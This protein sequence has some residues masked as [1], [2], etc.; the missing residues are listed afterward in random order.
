MNEWK[1]LSRGALLAGLTALLEGVARPL[2][3]SPVRAAVLAAVEA[4][5]GW[6][7]AP[8]RPETE[9]PTVAQ[10]QGM[11][12][13][14]LYR[15]HVPGLLSLTSTVARSSREYAAIGATYQILCFVVLQID[16]AEGAWCPGKPN[17]LPSDVV[18]ANGSPS[19]R[20]S[21][22]VGRPRWTQRPSGRVSRN[23]SRRSPPTFPTPGS[24]L[25]RSRG[26]WTWPDELRSDPMAGTLRGRDH[27]GAEGRAS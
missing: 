9:A 8:E 7:D 18:E 12:S 20:A 2:P 26:V 24:P 17:V 27:Q 11:A 21:P 1:D 10:A 14:R 3:E 23:W 13:S 5:W 15:A 16:A 22:G 19:R 4:V 6:L 25:G